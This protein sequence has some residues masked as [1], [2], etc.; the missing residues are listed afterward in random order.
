MARPYD[1]S[2]SVSAEHLRAILRYEPE[3]GRFI[4]LVA[5]HGKGGVK[6]IGAEA[7]ITVKGR[8][9]V[10]INGRRYAAHRLAWFFMTGKW[11]VEVDHENRDPLDNRWAN[12]REATRSQNNFNV[13][14]KRHNT[15]GIKGV[16]WDKSRLRWKAQISIN[17]KH[18]CLGRFETKEAA[19]AA[20]QTAA[21]Q[22]FGE[23]ASA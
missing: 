13:G 6:P 14:L 3:T 20:Y 19:A 23:F 9:Y 5:T 17:S 12:L 22:H 21:Q 8:R 18:L 1:P 10:D 15:S 16:S 7:G 2:T 4:R 11:P